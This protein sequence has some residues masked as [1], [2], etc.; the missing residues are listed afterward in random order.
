M[1]GLW[2][3][4]GAVGMGCGWIWLGSVLVL[5]LICLPSP[6]AQQEVQ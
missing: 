4:G 1:Q 2:E 6:T 5:S 3:K